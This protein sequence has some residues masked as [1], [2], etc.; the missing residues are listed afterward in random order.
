MTTAS[1]PVEH[2]SLVRTFPDLT[3]WAIEALV[4]E[5]ASL[6]DRWRQEGDT[7]LGACLGKD[8][9]AVAD[10]MRRRVDTKVEGP[11][12][13]LPTF[14]LIQIENVDGF[15]GCLGHHNPDD[16]DDLTPEQ[17]RKIALDALNAAEWIEAN[18]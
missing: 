12:D 14:G 11:K 5:L 9:Y 1:H 17:L 13:V 7:E 8:F 18:R 3:K 4:G 10:E 2:Y 6:G 15:G 16:L